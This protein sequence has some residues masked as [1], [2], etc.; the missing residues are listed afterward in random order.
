MPRKNMP[1]NWEPPAPA[2][3]S[4]WEQQA[5][6]LV[7]GYFGIQADEPELLEPW[8]ENAFGGKYA[9]F[10]VEVGRHDGKDGLTEFLYIAYWRRS[11]YEKWWPREQSW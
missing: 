9:P 2:W 4:V 10:A 1:R 7:A 3:Q 8:A 5:D 11:Q 6:P